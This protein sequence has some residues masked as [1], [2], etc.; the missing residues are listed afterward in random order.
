MSSVVER[1][2]AVARAEERPSARPPARRARPSGR[3]L[4]VAAFV[5]LV[6]VS[7]WLRTRALDAGFWIDEGIA[8]GISSYDLLDIPGV[9]R[10]DGSPPLYYLL[11]HVWMQGFGMTETATHVLSL[12]FA[13]LSIP[14]ALWAGRSL[15]GARAG[16]IAAVLAALSPFLT[17]YAQETRMYALAALVSILVSATFVHLFA[18]RDRRY[19]IPFALS[20]A[21]MLYVHNWAVFLIAGTLCALALLLRWAA[22]DERRGL[23]RDGALAYGG[24]LLLYLPWIPT[25]LF[26]AVHT[27]APWAERPGVDE[28]TKGLGYL[29]GGAAAAVALLLVA[30][31]ALFARLRTQRDERIAALV[32]LTGAS[33]LLAFLVSQVSPAFATRYFASF[34]GPLLLVAAVGLTRAGRLGLVCLVIVAAFWLDPKTTSLRSKSDVRAVATSIQSIVTAGD[35]I[36]STHPEQLPV[37]AY[38]LPDGV[39]YADSLGPVEDPRVFDWTD[40]VQRLRDA[41]PTP[42]INRLLATLAPGQELVLVQPILRTYRW[43]APWT[44]LVRRRALQWERRL[45]RDPRVRREAVVPVFGYDPLPRGIR[46]IVY[47]VRDPRDAR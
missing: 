22:P 34:L 6:A 11:L 27:G 19:V 20:L 12:V 14:A 37:V 41:K 46:A 35:L 29:L 3:V 30:G 9:L 28:L 40:A 15:F 10:K 47:R 33:I 23:L 24:A 32:V 16:W 13:L 4:G 8:V 36:V 25:L 43:R 31:N 5:A 45:D 1:P 7:A 42:T 17:Y 21:T 2:A 18:A 44:K 26:Q 38:Y 39:R